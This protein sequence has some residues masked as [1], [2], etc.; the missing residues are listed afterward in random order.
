MLELLFAVLLLLYHMGQYG[1]VS[2]AQASDKI[3]SDSWVVHIHQFC[4]PDT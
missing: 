1:I 4:F 3:R 2:Q